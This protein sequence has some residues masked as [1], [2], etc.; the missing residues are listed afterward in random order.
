MRRLVHSAT[1]EAMTSLLGAGVALALMLAGC[2]GSSGGSST[3]SARFA[4]TYPASFHANFARGCAAAKDSAAMCSCAVGY[5]ENSVHYLT[6]VSEAPTIDY[7]GPSLTVPNAPT[8]FNRLQLS[9]KRHGAGK[10]PYIAPRAYAFLLPPPP[11]SSKVQAALVPLINACI[12]ASFSYSPGAP[13]P[14]AATRGT[15]ELLQLARTYS[16]VAPMSASIGKIT[17][18]RK[19]VVAAHDF[20]AHRC[21]PSDAARVSAALSG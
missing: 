1:V 16:L 20:L 17:T 15:N 7:T 2:G 13:A 12:K 8:W 5:T 11:P 3:P 19:A 21:S 18:L 14:A 6:L 9:C 4:S 10:P